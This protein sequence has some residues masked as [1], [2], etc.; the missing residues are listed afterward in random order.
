[1]DLY[2]HFQSVEF[3]LLRVELTLL[4]LLCSTSTSEH[5]AQRQTSI[6]DFSKRPVTDKR[7]RQITDLLVN[8]VIKDIRPLSA[9]SGEGF[10]DIIKFFEPG[11][12]I[13]SHVTLWKNIT[14]QYNTV[15][16]RIAK[17]MKDKSVSLTTDLW[18]SCTMDP[19]ITITAHYITD[20]WELKSRVLRTTLMPE[21][22]TTVN[23]AQRLKE[24]IEEWDLDFF[25]LSMT[26]QAACIWRWSSAS[27]FP[28][29]LD[30]L[31]T[32][33]N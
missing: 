18:T 15:K 17:E 4:I 2:K 5:T 19:Y 13:P 12:T 11:H 9:L 1:M 30:A 28:T 27:S 22:H 14:L 24:T 31:D 23:I 29:T 32:L 20:S 16:A 10:K 7:R 33:F 8:F 3:N 6:I 25:A 26:T 21:R